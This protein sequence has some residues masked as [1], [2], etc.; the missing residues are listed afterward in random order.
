MFLERTTNPER[1]MTKLLIHMKNKLKIGIIGCGTIGSELARACEGALSGVVTLAAICDKDPV[2]SSLLRS[3]LKDR[4]PVLDTDKLIESSDIVVEAASASVSAG[5]L[6]KSIKSKKDILIMS[7]GGLI[8]NETLLDK[9]A[10]AGIKVYLPS[11]AIAGV[12]ALKSV[13]AARIESVTLTTRKPPKG[14]E[15]AP[16]IVK[17]GIDLSA[18]KTETV[19]F[20]GSAREAIK[21]FPANVNVCACLSLAGIGA[22]RTRVKI[23]TSPSYTKNVHEVEIK[24]DAG[25]ITTRTENLPSASNPKTSYL[26]VLSAIATLEGAA[27]SVKVGT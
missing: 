1:R 21:G 15:G 3:S 24:S 23:V 4:V 10:K 9:A 14:L 22:D 13:S 17:H 16:Y 7:V 27:K 26:A 11:G 25:V 12:D 5:I 8:G 19:V 20:E 2:K 18:V 6:E